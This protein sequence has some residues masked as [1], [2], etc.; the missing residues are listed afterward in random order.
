MA[1]QMQPLLTPQLTRKPKINKTPFKENN[2]S[3]SNTTTRRRKRATP[4]NFKSAYD[5]LKANAAMLQQQDEPDIDNLMTTVEES[6][7]AYKV[8][9]ER[10]DAVKQALDETFADNAK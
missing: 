4:K 8:C 5:M 7:S 3:N 1:L 2:M 6:I 10:I 9:Q